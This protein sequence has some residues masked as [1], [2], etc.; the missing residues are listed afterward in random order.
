MIR[1]GF[2]VAWVASTSFCVYGWVRGSGGR[3]QRVRHVHPPKV[4]RVAKEWETKR[5]D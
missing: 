4:A 5:R 2:A 3:R 1:K